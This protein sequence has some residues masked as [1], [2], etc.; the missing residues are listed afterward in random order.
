MPESLFESDFRVEDFGGQEFANFGQSKPD[1]DEADSS[2]GSESDL[3]DEELEVIL[4]PKEK[5]SNP[6]KLKR[7]VT[8]KRKTSQPKKR[9]RAQK[10]NNNVIKLQDMEKSDFFKD[11]TIKHH[12]PRSKLNSSKLV[13]HPDLLELDRSPTVITSRD[14]HKDSFLMSPSKPKDLPKTSKKRKRARIIH[15]R[16]NISTAE[17]GIRI[18]HRHRSHKKKGSKHK[19]GASAKPV[20]KPEPTGQSLQKT[21]L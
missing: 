1:K 8:H 4:M 9:H 15:A 17:K 19:K 3:E 11:D 12:P 7:K 6:P 14:D 10:S 20:S 5:P 13:I 2:S 16:Q 18:H 21:P